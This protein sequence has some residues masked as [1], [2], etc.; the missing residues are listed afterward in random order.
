MYQ[1]SECPN[2]RAPVEPPS[3][4]YTECESC[5]SILEKKTYHDGSIYFELAK[6][7]AKITEASSKSSKEHSTIANYITQTLELVE[8]NIAQTK[9]T[10]KSIANSIEKSSSQATQEFRTIDQHNAEIEKRLRDRLDKQSELI[11]S[12]DQ[13]RDIKRDIEKC[14]ADIKQNPGQS[15]YK[16]QLQSLMTRS[17]QLEK[18]ILNLRKEL[19]PEQ[20]K[21]QNKEDIGPFGIILALFFLIGLVLFILG[22]ILNI[23]LN[24]E[25]IFIWV[26]L[27]LLATAFIMLF[28][29]AI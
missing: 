7:D 18:T 25:T 2:C 27:D 4:A 10:Q 14:Q 28:L 13:L 22:V 12:E 9:G 3:G 24:P 16:V 19:Y 1:A 11:R 23:P 15:L 20:F 8:K 29:I 17:S 26:F 21:S 6:L 5:H